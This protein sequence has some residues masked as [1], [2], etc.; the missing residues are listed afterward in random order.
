MARQANIGGGERAAQLRGTQVIAA[1]AVL[2]AIEY[3]LA[4]AVSSSA[5]LVALLTP[6]A[7][8]KA[9]LIA[10]SFMHLARVWRGE[11]QH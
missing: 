2:T 8:V 7:L 1:L 9:Y 10:M 11:E 3:A 5:L 6:I 4:V